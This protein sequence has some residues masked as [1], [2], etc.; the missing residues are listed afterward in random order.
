MSLYESVQ[1]NLKEVFSH[2]QDSYDENLLEPLLHP[3]KILEVSV[4]VKMDDGSTKVFTGYRS[5]HNN[6]R[7][8]YKWWI[9]FHQNVSKDEVMSL[10]V[11]M[12]M[13]TAVVGIPLGGGKWWVIVNPRELS[14]NELK[15][16]SKWYMQAI[17]HDIGADTDIPA[18]DVNTNAQIMARMYDA[19][20]QATG[21]RTPGVITGKPL[22]LGGSAWRDIATSLWGLY[23]L[24]EYFDYHNDSLEWKKIAIQWS[25]NAGMNFAKL[26][27]KHGAKVI[28]ISDSSGWVYHEDGLDIKRAEEYKQAGNKFVDFSDGQFI[29]NEEL[30][31]L[32]VDVLVPAALENQITMDNASQVRASIILE[33]AN[34][35]IALNANDV[36][37]DKWVVVIPDVLANAGGVTVSYFEQ[38]QNN[39][40]YYRPQ[41]EV[42][43]KLEK[44]IKPATEK[45]ITTAEQHSTSLRTGAYI[46]GL[47]RILD[48]SKLTQ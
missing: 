23:V 22:S 6:N 25:G 16:L 2:L 37:N 15:Q 19:Y 8:P 35:P 36:L 11:W 27:V 43:E 18:P 3:H 10:S 34:G 13:K 39:T 32:D 48:V 33:L 9:R 20:V 42:F 46:V 21:K 14:Q 7:G 30:L 31:L 40:N 4:P 41:E 28:A 5:Q 29:S 1:Q 12:T 26:A 47:K 24:Q 17:A 44:I 38:V 45:V